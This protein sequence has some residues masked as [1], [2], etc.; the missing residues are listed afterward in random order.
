MTDRLEIHI[1]ELRKKAKSREDEAIQKWLTFFENPYG[2]EIKEM[3]EEKE[4][5]KV[6]LEALEEINADEEKVRI[7][8]LREKYILDRNTEIRNAKEIGISQGRKLGKQE[9]MLEMAKKMKKKGMDVKT[10]IEVTEL[11]EE[12]IK[13]I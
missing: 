9:G 11:T 1:I 7:A 5:I 8:E 6:A 3:S 4:E 2:R 12:E 10:I 13:K